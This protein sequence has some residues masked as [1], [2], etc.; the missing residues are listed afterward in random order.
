MLACKPVSDSVLWV[1]GADIHTDYTKLDSFFCG[2]NTRKKCQINKEEQ[3]AALGAS[4]ACLHC[5]LCS[6]HFSKT[7]T[8]VKVM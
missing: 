2:A 6:K 4:P 1:A 8:S 7:L 5:N 3:V